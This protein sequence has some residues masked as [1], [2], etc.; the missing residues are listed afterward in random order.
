MVHRAAVAK[1]RKIERSLLRFDYFHNI[2]R[3]LEFKSKEW[4]DIGIMAFVMAFIF[5]FDNWGSEAFNFAIG[6]S[7]FS[8]YFII[9]FLV[10]LLYVI[11]VK[12]IGIFNGLRVTYEKYT[13][14]ILFSVFIAFLTF[15]KLPIFIPG[16]LKYESIYNLRVGKFRATMAKDWE[17]CLTAGSGPVSMLIL[18]IP[19]QII[20]ATT[21]VPFF[22]SFIIVALLTA[23]F[24]LI[25]LPVISTA[26]PYEG[27]MNRFNIFDGG[28]IGYDI[29]FN[30]R[31][32]FFFLAGA[33][34]AY[35]LLWQIFGYVSI[36]FSSIVGL[37][38]LISYH[39][40]SVVK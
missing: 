18:I 19:L 7:N 3:Y 5:S 11:A 30:D 17:T 12:A 14:S 34:I 39:A 21:G 29:F 26:N 20:F 28:S 35:A 32:W 27:Y 1:T 2:H 15:G 36:L 24:S 8:K 40:I 25:P 23:A 16:V 13:V 33:I 37:V 9:S 4:L 10:M 6:F 31:N 38:V 22:K